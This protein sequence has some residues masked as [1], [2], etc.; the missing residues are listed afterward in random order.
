AVELVQQVGQ[1]ERHWERN[2][3]HGQRDGLTE[4]SRLDQLAT[5]DV[6]H[7]QAG[8]EN[9][10]E[11]HEKL[12]SRIDH[13]HWREANKSELAV[14]PCFI[15]PRPPAYVMAQPIVIPSTYQPL[16]CDVRV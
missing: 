14:Q 12:L 8:R 13:G 2:H 16:C 5:D 1:Q 9:G 6:A 15:Y 3:P 7:D 10:S 4:Q 11:H